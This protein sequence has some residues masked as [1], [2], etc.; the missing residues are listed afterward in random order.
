[1]GYV[2]NEQEREV[3]ERYLE[4]NGLDD[5]REIQEAWRD[6]CDELEDRHFNS[7]REW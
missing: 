3:F 1:M 5:D 6:Y 7:R 2:P 4:R